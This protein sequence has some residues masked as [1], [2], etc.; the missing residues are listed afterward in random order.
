MSFMH[1][2]SST[3]KIRIKKELMLSH[4]NETVTYEDESFAQVHQL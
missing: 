2:G 4:N 3:I 1:L